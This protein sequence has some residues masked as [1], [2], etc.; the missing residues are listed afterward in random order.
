[1]RI[2]ELFKLND[3]R[4]QVL[5][6]PEAFREKD[7]CLRDAV[8]AMAKQRD[9]ELEDPDLRKPARKALESLGNHW[10]GL[11]VFV[12]H[13]DVPM[14]NN[15]AERRI[16]SPVTGRK[17][18]YGSGSQWSGTLARQMFSTLQTVLLWG[19]NPD[20]WLRSFLQ[21]CAERGG[22]TPSDLSAFLP[23][24]LDEERKR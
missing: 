16:R 24:A 4:L 17:A 3:E 13:P 18:Y 11:T 9:R 22:R 23:S 2:N 5:S 21:A 8:D 20:H 1:M 19:L 10:E 6:D 7:R 15:A 14:D 12:D